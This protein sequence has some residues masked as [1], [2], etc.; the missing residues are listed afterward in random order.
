MVCFAPVVGLKVVIILNHSEHN[1][2]AAGLFVG[3]TTLIAFQMSNAS[4]AFYFEVII[5]RTC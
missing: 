4:C 3:H 5:K 1:K 2:Q